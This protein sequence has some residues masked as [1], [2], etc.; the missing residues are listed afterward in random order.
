[1]AGTVLLVDRAFDPERCLFGDDALLRDEV[2]VMGPRELHAALRR[3]AHDDALRL[4]IAE[5]QRRHVLAGALGDAGFGIAL[6]QAIG[7]C[8]RAQGG[9]S[10]C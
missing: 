7:A 10:H 2:Y 4:R 5:A 9:A 1:M 8:M 3:L 6:R